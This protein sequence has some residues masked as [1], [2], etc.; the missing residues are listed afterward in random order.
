MRGVASLVIWFVS[1]GLAALIFIVLAKMVAGALP[2]S[3]GSGV[4]GFV[5][6]A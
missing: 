2:G 4:Q 1:V 3:V 5:G 6:R